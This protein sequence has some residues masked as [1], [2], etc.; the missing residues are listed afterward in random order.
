M[1]EPLRHSR[2]GSGCRLSL[3]HDNKLTGQSVILDRSARPHKD[4][5]CRR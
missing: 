1:T 2:G 4:V 3:E 5:Y